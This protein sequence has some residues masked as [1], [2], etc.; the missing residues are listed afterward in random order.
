MQQLF[1]VLN[2]AHSLHQT[3]L[4]NASSFLMTSLKLVALEK[5]QFMNVDDLTLLVFFARHLPY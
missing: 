1:F 2:F 4:A 5:P 3:K